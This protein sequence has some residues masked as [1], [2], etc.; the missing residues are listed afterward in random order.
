MTVY[1]ILQ[2]GPLDGEKQIVESLPTDPGSQMLFS[3]PNWQTFAPDGTTVVDLG[4]EEV[5][6]YLQPGPPPVPA[7]GD[8][9]DT[10]WIFK[11]AGEVYV[12]TP[13]PITPP[14]VPPEV[15]GNQVAMFVNGNLTVVYSTSPGAQFVA[16]SLLDVQGT[17]TPFQSAQVTMQAVSVLQGLG[18][19]IFGCYLLAYSGLSVAATTQIGVSMSARAGMMG[20]VGQNLLD[21]QAASVE[22][23]TI[24][25][26]TDLYR[27]AVLSNVTTVAAAGTHSLALTTVANG[28]IGTATTAPYRIPVVAGRPYN[29]SGQFRAATIG[30]SCTLTYHWFDASGATIGT[31]NTVSV[32]DNSTGWVTVSGQGITPMAGAVSMDIGPFISGC[33]AG[34]VHYVDNFAVQ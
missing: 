26:W 18:Y 29:I 1:M 11:F 30:R 14:V 32:T 9:W 8:T 31:F 16:E 3:I 20:A 2:G 25:G 28:A 23:G 12:P 7:N 22:D 6:T 5:Y 27:N 13:P 19:S 33:V 17:V 34:E 10:S 4:L 21:P 15:A 24:T